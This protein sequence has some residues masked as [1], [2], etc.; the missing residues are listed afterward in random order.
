M[1]HGWVVVDKPQGMSSA[2]VVAK[3]KRLFNAK[4]AGHG[5]TLDPLATGVLPIALGE[6]TKTL[7]YVLDGKK[8]YRF[9]VKWGEERSTDDREGEITATSDIRPNP[10]D[11]EKMLSS[12]IGQ[13]EQVPPIYSAL[14]VNGERAYALARQ[15]KEVVL[16]PRQVEIESL[17]LIQ[18]SPD[19]ACFEV[20]CSKGTYV[21]SLARDFALHLGT[22]GHIISLR[23][24]MAGPFQE[25]D[26]ILLDSLLQIGHN[27]ELIKYV[28]PLQD[29]LVDILA[30]EI[31][32][33]EAVKLRQGQTIVSSHKEREDVALILCGGK[34]LALAK[35]GEGR[36]TPLRVFNME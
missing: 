31:Q 2:D 4:K 1:I 32:G 34:P 12:F 26:A 10:Q 3:I 33:I 36:I 23:R 20:V 25:K 28:L 21:R 24:L 5:G 9:E 13:I 7:S 14:K 6:A 18:T 30:L 11:I 22:Y 19:S 29:A 8:S 17:R 16:T 15:G 35:V 27:T